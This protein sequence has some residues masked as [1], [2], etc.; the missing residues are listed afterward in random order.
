VETKIFIK[1]DMNDLSWVAVQIKPNMVKKACQNLQNQGFEHFAPCRWETIK[2]NNNFCRVEKLLFPGYI[3]VR[4]NIGSGHISTLNA[5][6]G[7]SR[8]VRGTGTDV[9][10]IPDGFIEELMFACGS[11]TTTKANIKTGDMVRLVDGPFVGVVGEVLSTDSNGRLRIL[12]ELMAGT[13]KLTAD[14][15][16]F[17]IVNG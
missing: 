15:N 12:F 9:G 8:V 10:I 11:G 5:T 1:P 17:E 13:S 16:S 7:L 4:C 14:L 3:F 2:S 6:M